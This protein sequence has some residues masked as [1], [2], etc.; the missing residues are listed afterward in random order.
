VPLSELS[1]RMAWGA[2]GCLLL[3][4]DEASSSEL[5]DVLGFRLRF[6]PDASSGFCFGRSKAASR[7]LAGLAGLGGCS[8]SS[9]SSNHLWMS[10]LCPSAAPIE[11]GTRA[12]NASRAAVGMREDW[13]LQR[14]FRLGSRAAVVQHSKG[15]RA[16]ESV[17]SPEQASVDFGVV[18][19]EAHR[20]TGVYGVEGKRQPSTRHF[21]EGTMESTDQAVVCPQYSSW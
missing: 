2:T 17:R 19:P 3:S 1:S 4:W 16:T 18:E 13:S 11:P 7:R 10:M 6:F 9:V 8:G 21:S 12:D 20:G 5:S 15:S 14:R